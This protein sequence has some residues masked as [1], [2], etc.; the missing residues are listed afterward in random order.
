MSKQIQNTHISGEFGV[1]QFAKYCNQHN[2]YIIFREIS[3]S[4]FGIDGEVELTRVNEDRKTEP[5]GEIMKVQIKTV[6]SDNSYIRN[7][8]ATTFEFYPRKE[9][10]EYWEKY[11]KNGIEVLLV[12]YDNRKDAL[13][14]KKV[15]DTDVFVGKENLKKGKKK[16]TNAVTFHKSDNLLQPST[17][18]F[19]VKFSNSFKTRV[20]FG[21]QE[22][23]LTN[24]LK[25]QQHP[26]QMYVYECQY[27]NKE[28][29]YKEIT[30]EEAP[31][32]I[33]KNSQVYTATELGN[34]YS[35]F[36]KK[37]LQDVPAKLI[38]YAQI[39][40]DRKLRNYYIELLNQYLKY[41][42]RTKKMTFQKDYNRYYFW[43]PKEEESVIIPAVTRKRGQQT[44]KEAVKKYT[45]GKLT[46]FRHY[47]LECKHFFL[48][49][50]LYLILQP[51]YY[52]TENG[53]TPLAPKY[54]TKL[55]NYLTS[56]EYNNHFCDWLHFWFSY[57]SAND[58]EL[59]VFED[60]A[61]KTITSVKPRS[62][63]A[64]HLRIMLSDY[65]VFPVN[66]GIP[67]DKKE[68][69]KASNTSD[70]AEQNLLFTI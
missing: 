16:N 1:I 35:S 5:L 55:T 66:F 57:L 60:P 42:F 68:R 25:Y 24:F 56:R 44:Q 62:F 27:T 36:K 2:P 40:E 70:G 46:F 9:D 20:A 29:I 65:T 39:L 4:D 38:T 6:S 31:F 43:I 63:Y 37:V 48:C 8:R 19:T 7:E 51:K 33:A 53:K 52:F 3:K 47:A 10:I 59:I 15:I 11:K 13:Y 21:I 32:F 12:I 58:K 50:E 49:N 30:Q 45:Y 23:L 61:Y 18:D 17:N 64:K 14:C 69:R 34:G 22:Y 26:K 67:L 54:I 28:A 41:F